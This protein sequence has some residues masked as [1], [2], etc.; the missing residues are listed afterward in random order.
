METCST[1]PWNNYTIVRARL[2]AEQPTDRCF[3]CCVQVQKG[4]NE[5]LETKRQ[6]FPRFYFLSNDELL[7][8]LS[9]TKDPERVQPYL[10]KIFDGISRLEMLPNLEV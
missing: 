1:L 7:E 5:Y 2:R 8:I 6:V 4:L 9:K 10:C 3:C